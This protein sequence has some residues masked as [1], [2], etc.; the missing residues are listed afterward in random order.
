MT[1]RGVVLGRAI[2]RAHPLPANWLL[3]VLLVLDVLR[4]LPCCKSI[5]IFGVV[6]AVQRISKH[7]RCPP[8]T[9]KCRRV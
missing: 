4:S 6:G 3:Q 7:P 8:E 5:N 9:I 2:L 1:I